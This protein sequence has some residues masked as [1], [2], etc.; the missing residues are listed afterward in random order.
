M[1]ESF[2]LMIK[3]KTVYYEGEDTKMFT[4]S[5]QSKNWRSVSA[6]L[7]QPWYVNEVDVKVLINQK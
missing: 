4:E 5:K 1:R 6:V 3:N 2:I 7:C